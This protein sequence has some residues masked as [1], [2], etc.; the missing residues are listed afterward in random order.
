MLQSN[1]I[2]LWHNKYNLKA[3]IFLGYPLTSN[4]T[5]LFNYLDNIVIKLKQQASILSQRNLFILR[6]SLI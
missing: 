6:C 2:P 3:A 5:Q 4:W 1:G